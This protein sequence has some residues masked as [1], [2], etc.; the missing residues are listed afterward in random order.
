MSENS[1]EECNYEK[2]GVY[3]GEPAP[4]FVLNTTDGNSWRLSEQVGKVT[5]LLF[6]PKNETLVCT[7]QLCS[8]RDNWGDYLRAKVSI[9]GISKGTIEK[10]KKFANDNNLPLPLLADTDG[11]I[12][13]LYC[14]LKTVPL[15]FTRAVFVIDAKGIVR[16]RDVMLRIF[17]PS[18]E[19]ILSSIHRAKAE[20]WI[21]SADKN[22]LNEQ[23]E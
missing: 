7:K 11:R 9:V 10:H 22:I 15:S 12:T 18:D 2:A 20:T 17:R 3:V 13:R 6:Y 23:Y 16:N 8:V 5:V 21:H 14:R 1:F 4:D 19:E